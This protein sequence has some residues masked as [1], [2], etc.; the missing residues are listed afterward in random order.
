M[1]SLVV[2]KRA[3]IVLFPDPELKNKPEAGQLALRNT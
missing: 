3:K 2:M 1:I